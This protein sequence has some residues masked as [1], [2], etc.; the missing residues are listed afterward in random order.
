MHAQECRWFIDANESVARAACS[1]ALGAAQLDPVYC[2][3][4][5]TSASGGVGCPDWRS[6]QPPGAVN[7]STSWQ[8]HLHGGGWCYGNSDC[9]SRASTSLGSST[10]FN[11]SV[12]ASE[13]ILSSDPGQ[14]PRFYGWNRAE[15]R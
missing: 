6:P 14:N 4:C 5:N 3:P 9:A 10:R 15:I 2:L 8:I 13:G 7:A 11:I 1:R 12:V